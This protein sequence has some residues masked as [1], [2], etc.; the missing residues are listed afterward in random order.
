MVKQSKVRFSQHFGKSH[1]TSFPVSE[2]LQSSIR[3]RDQCLYGDHRMSMCNISILTCADNHNLE[4]LEWI[5]VSKNKPELN[6]DQSTFPFVIFWN[7][8]IF[9]SS[10]RYSKFYLF[11]CFFDQVR[12]KSVYLICLFMSVLN[13]VCLWLCVLGTHTSYLA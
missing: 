1:V 11:F 6:I 3:V 8:G 9:F 13:Q 4:T 10:D 5:Y 12:S 7:F 2:P